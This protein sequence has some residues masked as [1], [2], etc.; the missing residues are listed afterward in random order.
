MI[1]DTGEH[2]DG[3]STIESMIVYLFGLHL[4]RKNAVAMPAE[5][6]EPVYLQR[7][8]MGGDVQIVITYSPAAATASNQQQPSSSELPKSYQDP[9]S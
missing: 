1:L 9:L 7:E 3:S 6:Q 2:S 4:Q 8:G 5:K